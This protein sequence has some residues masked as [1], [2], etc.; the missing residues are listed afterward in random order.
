MAVTSCMHL[1]LFAWSALV[2]DMLEDLGQMVRA[3]KPPRISSP[4]YVPT[5]VLF[6]LTTRRN[7]SL[8]PPRRRTTKGTSVQRML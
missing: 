2:S 6:P 8:T 3:R 4:L 7:N 1:Y 5:F